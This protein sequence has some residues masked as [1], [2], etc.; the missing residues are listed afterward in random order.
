MQNSSPRLPLPWHA[1][2]YGIRWFVFVAAIALGAMIV[3]TCL[4]VL[5]RVFKIPLT[6]A[7]DVVRICSAIALAGALPATTAAKGHVTIEYFFHRL[8]RTG[9]RIVD[10]FVHGLLVVC[11]G[12]A[13]WQCVHAGMLFL[14]NGQSTNT[15]QIPLFWVFWVMALGFLFSAFASLFHLLYP[16]NASAL[17]ANAKGGGQ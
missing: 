6:G 11:F 12:V 3:I 14:A 2:A 5:L 9:R 4:D 13:L 8:N 17:W 1:I 15:I 10:I 16:S 7:N